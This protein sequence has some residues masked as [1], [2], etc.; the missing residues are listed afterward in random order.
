MAF[1][2]L[3]TVILVGEGDAVVVTADQSPIGNGDPVCVAGEVLE[4]GFWAGKRPFGY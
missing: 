4:D 1:A 2:T 3:G